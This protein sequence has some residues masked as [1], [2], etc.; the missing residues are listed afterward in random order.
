MASVSA[1]CSAVI[2][3]L[4]QNDNV[5]YFLQSFYRGEIS[6]SAQIASLI[7]A[8]DDDD[9]SDTVGLRD[10]VLRNALRESNNRTLKS[11]SSGASVSAL[12]SGGG[13]SSG[14]ATLLSSASKR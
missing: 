6:E 8:V 1:T 11:G 9:S 3:I 13:A 2:H 4:D 12:S 14:S 7:L 10:S 5:P